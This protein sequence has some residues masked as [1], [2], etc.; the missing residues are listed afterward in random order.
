MYSGMFGVSFGSG[1]W[2]LFLRERSQR[3]FVLYTR[4]RKSTFHWSSIVM[5]EVEIGVPFVL[6]FQSRS[7]R[8]VVWFLV[9]LWMRPCRL[10]VK[11]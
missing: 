9:I 8:G 4:I 2:S 1:S 10:V 3:L 6:L 11:S 7:C 5:I